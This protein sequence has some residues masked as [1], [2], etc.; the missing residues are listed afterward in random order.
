MWTIGELKYQARQNLSRS[1]WKSV[2][3]AF[4]LSLGI[5]G[6]GR[7]CAMLSSL[8]YGFLPN[9]NFSYSYH[10]GHGDYFHSWGG[11]FGFAGYLPFIGLAV[12]IGIGVALVLRIAIAFFLCGPLEVGSRRWFIVNRYRIRNANDSYAPGAT[13]SCTEIVHPFSKGYLNVVKGIFL[14]WLYITLWSLLFIV[15]GIIKSYSYRL[16]PYILA[17]SP[18]MDTREAFRLSRAMMDGNKAHA[19]GLD[20]SFILW[21]LLSLVTFGIAGFFYVEPYRAQTNMELYLRLRDNYLGA[22]QNTQ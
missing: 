3:A 5:G 19:F 2:L 9:W 18:E 10:G 15:P 22:G 6:A 12:G 7:I 8:F 14:R 11:P 4:V 20:L 16:V 17:E 13:A 1:Y 21:E